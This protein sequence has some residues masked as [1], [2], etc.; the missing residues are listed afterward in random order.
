MFTM[1]F[2]RPRSNQPEGYHPPRTGVHL[3]NG[4]LILPDSLMEGLFG[5]EHQL[6][7]W[8]RVEAGLLV[9]GKPGHPLL[10]H[11]PE[12]RLQLVKHRSAQ[13]ERAVDI[14]EI[15]IDH[16]LRDRAH[17]LRVE[18]RP[19]AGTLIVYLNENG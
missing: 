14:R 13:G 8:Y 7:V 10:G 4:H 9:L 6:Y 1:I 12:A 2:P 18:S 11:E 5:P 16:D 15:C 19:K 17:A 3:E